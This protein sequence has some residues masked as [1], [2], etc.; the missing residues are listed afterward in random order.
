LTRI[1]LDHLGPAAVDLAVVGE[2]WRPYDHVNVQAGLDAWLA[3][4]G[5]E[6][7]LVGVAGFQNTEF[8]LAELLGA[9]QQPPWGPRPGN[10]ASA[11]LPSGPDGAVQPCVLCGL[12]LVTEGDRYTA[13]LL[14]GPDPHGPHDAVTVQIAGTEP[15]AAAEAAT[16]IRRL[17]LEHNVFR[18][19]V[20][21]F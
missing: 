13:L 21:S 2:S 14:R 10:V 12:Y 8:G 19:Q 7:R 16:E 20:L 4:P 18:G 17:A 6:Y 15:A 9:G 1:L 11:N 5:R 3:A